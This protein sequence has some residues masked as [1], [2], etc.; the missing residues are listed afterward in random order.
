MAAL[1]LSRTPFTVTW[2]RGCGAAVLAVRPR[3]LSIPL[4]VPFLALPTAALALG[5]LDFGQSLLKCPYA[6][7]LYH[8]IL[9][10]SHLGFCWGQ[11]LFKWPT[12]LQPWHTEDVPA[13]KG[14]GGATSP[15]A[16]VAHKA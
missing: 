15:A 9:L 11:S 1:L 8:W 13:A 10:M 6:L 7:H 2:M 3:H 12:E 14:G 16:S 4:A 5:G